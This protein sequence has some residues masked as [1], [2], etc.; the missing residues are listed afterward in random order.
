MGLNFR[1][2]RTELRPIREQG[3]GL[4][5][6][7]LRLV[8]FQEREQVRLF[9]GGFFHGEEVERIQIAIEVKVARLVENIG[10]A[11]R[12]ARAEVDAG[13]SEHRH[14]ATRH[15]FAAMVAHALHHKR[16]PGI[17]HGETLTRRAG[18]EDLTRGRAVGDDIADISLDRN[19]T[20]GKALAD[21]V[22]RLAIEREGD[23]V[24]EKRAEGLSRRAGEVYS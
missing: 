21:I 15:V 5:G 19:L 16:R 17:A 22:V 7:G 11:A 14:H 10:N 13:R 2:S 23:I 18:D 4:C 20:A 8:P 24:M 1:E 12:H 3:G 6:T 9:R